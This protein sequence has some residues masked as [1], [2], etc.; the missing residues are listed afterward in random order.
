MKASSRVYFVP[1]D[2]KEPAESLSAKMR[3]AYLAVGFNEKIAEDDFVAMKI[4]FGEKTQYGIHQAA[5]AR[6]DRLR[7]P[8]ADA[9]G[10]SSRT[11]TRSTSGS[12]RT[13]STTSSWPGATVSRPTSSTS[14]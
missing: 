4:H 14:R 6:G 7:A 9:R 10:P 3:K 1:A 2:G 5:M 8:E 11:R 13:P 12:V